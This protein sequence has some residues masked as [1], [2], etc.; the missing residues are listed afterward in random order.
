MSLD[1]HAEAKRQ[2]DADRAR[3]A[4]ERA[5]LPCDRQ[6]AGG[7]TCLDV[8]HSL[9]YQGYVPHDVRE[10]QT[11]MVEWACAWCLEQREDL[12]DR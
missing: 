2:W 7:T 9:R 3:W 1:G 6:K 12:G 8:Y 10:K 5:A 11:P 4:A